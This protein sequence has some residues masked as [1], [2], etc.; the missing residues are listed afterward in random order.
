MN[1]RSKPIRLVVTTALA[2][3]ALGT[4]T[5]GTAQAWLN[6][7]PDVQYPSAGGKWTY[8]FWDAQVRS[9]YYHSSRCHG[10]TVVYNGAQERSID[11]APGWTSRADKWAFQASYNDDAYY[12]RTC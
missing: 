5:T 10:S 8:G 12:Y 7:G 9:Y 6:Y 3:V 2:A 4:A 11:T 1:K